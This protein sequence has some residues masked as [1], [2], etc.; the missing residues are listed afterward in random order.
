MAYQLIIH[1]AVYGVGSYLGY[2]AFV[3]I[4]HSYYQGD[5]MRIRN[6]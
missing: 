5:I 2:R 6:I 1:P 3:R 4:T